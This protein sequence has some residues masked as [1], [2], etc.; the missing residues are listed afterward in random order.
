MSITGGTA[1]Q[2]ATGANTVTPFAG[3]SVTDPNAD[4][5]DTLTITLSNPS[6]GTLTGT[7]LVASTTTP[8][9]YTLSGSATTIT[10]ELDGL[11]FHPTAA[12]AGQALL[13]SF[14]LTLADGVASPVSNN[15]T[16]VVD[17]AAGT[18]SLPGPHTQYVVANDGGVLS[19]ENT[20]V[21]SP[22]P[23]DLTGITDFV[24]GD[25]S[26][27]VF[28]PSGTAENIARL[29]QAAFGHEPTASQLNTYTTEVN[30]GN[31]SLTALGNSFLAPAGLSAVSNA[32]FINDVY[33]NALHRAADA[34]G[35]Q[36]FENELASGVS[37]GAVMV[38]I[39]ASQEAH[40]ASVSF[41]GDQTYGEVYRLFQAALDQGATW[42]QEANWSSAIANGSQSLAQLAQDLISS[43]SFVQKYGSLSNTAFVTTMWNNATHGAPDPDQ[44]SWINALTNGSSRGTVLMGIA[45]SLASRDATAAAT[46]AN[47]VFI[48]APA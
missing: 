7:G 48:P 20:S 31:V 14:A 18:T 30:S 43:S 22:A 29:Y 26:S 15:A 46:H 32:V 5:T 47:W 10:T 9:V 28:D 19:V 44:Q 38:T 45:D 34:G 33:E 39:A 42:A 3:V 6:N 36:T 16:S 13:T 2:A 25:G 1:N 12:A 11:V 4:V 21:P 8:G 35:L 37:R 41:A 40:T 24:F 23:Q 17:T 27:G